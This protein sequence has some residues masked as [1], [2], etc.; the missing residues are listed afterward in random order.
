MGDNTGPRSLFLQLPVPVGF[1]CLDRDFDEGEYATEVVSIFQNGFVISSP[2]KL[3]LGCLVSLRLRVPA[4]TGLFEE[5]RCEGRI[6]S[7]QTLKEGGLGYRV[8][9]DTALHG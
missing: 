3:R 2:Q 4:P 8:E 1:R 6:I 5:T 7:E 9:I